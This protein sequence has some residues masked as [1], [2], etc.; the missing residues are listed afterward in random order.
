MRKTL[1]WLLLCPIA[2]VWA[3]ENAGDGDSND[4]A[5]VTY[6]ICAGY[7]A[8]MVDEFRKIPVSTEVNHIIDTYLEAGEISTILA[9]TFASFDYPADIVEGL[10]EDAIHLE[11]TNFRDLVSRDV[12]LVSSLYDR[13]CERVIDEGV[14]VLAG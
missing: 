10:V 9:T 3:Q 1:A 6:T 12:Q 13:I 7:Y 5:Y 11:T 2:F 14:S 4:T 8:V